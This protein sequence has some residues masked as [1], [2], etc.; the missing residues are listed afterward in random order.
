MKKTIAYSELVEGKVPRSYDKVGNVSSESVKKHTG[1]DWK[2][3]VTELEK[4]GA[5]N[6]SHQEIVALLA[7]KYKLTPWWQQGVSLGFEIATGRRK[8]GQDAKGKYMVTATKSFSVDNKVLWKKLVSPAG[9]KIWMQPLSAVRLLPKAQ[10]ETK[11]GFFGEIRTMA[12]N[13]R[14]RVRWQEPYWESATTVE[15]HLVARPAKKSIL[16]FNHTGLA[17]AET[18]EAMRV[19]WRAA[20]DKL[21]ECFAG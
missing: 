4:R 7:K 11:D 8:V 9:I 19:R 10:F 13:R 16:V 20:A 21:A 5:R 17:D 12:V 1:K 6:L 3:W 18:K 2:Y 15:L 14:I